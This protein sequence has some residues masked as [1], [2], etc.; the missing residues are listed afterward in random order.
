MEV[1]AYVEARIKGHGLVPYLDKL[2]TFVALE[3]CKHL[4]SFVHKYRRAIGDLKPGLW[5]AP[6]REIGFHVVSQGEEYLRTVFA[7]IIRFKRDRSNSRTFFHSLGQWLQRHSK[8]ERARDI[9]ELFQDV[10]ERNLPFAPG[11]LC[12]VPVRRRYR[13][14]VHSAAA[15]YRISRDRIVAL[16]NDAGLLERRLHGFCCFDVKTI[17][18]LLS[19]TPKAFVVPRSKAR[20]ELGV[21]VKLMSAIMKSNLLPRVKGS[22]THHGSSIAIHDLTEFKQQVF[23]NVNLGDVD[24]NA[25]TIESLELVT[26]VDP[27]DALVALI[28]GKLKKTTAENDHGYRLDSLRFDRQ[29]VLGHWKIN[30]ETTEGGVGGD[31]LFTADAA[32]LL[33]VKPKTIPELV[34]LNILESGAAG[35]GVGGRSRTVTLASTTKFRKQYV[36]Q[37]EAAEIMRLKDAVYVLEQMSGVKPV[38]RATPHTSAV[39]LRCD[40]TR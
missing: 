8:D 35:S 13:H 10:A 36:V 39:Y 27:F 20:K 25:F 15:E 33:R 18:E 21:S 12:F 23:K 26:G 37:K 28:D 19:S 29:E 31:T 34:R 24:E 38:V 2:E 6:A 16:L 9:V 3:L 22:A 14:T 4:G 11:E 30:R 1:D 5:D 32:R 17:D 40:V 7:E